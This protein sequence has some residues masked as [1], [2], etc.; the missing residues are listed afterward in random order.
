VVRDMLQLFK[1]GGLLTG[2]VTGSV[3]GCVIGSVTGSVTGC[4]IG[5]V[6]GSKRQ[7]DRQY[8]RQEPALQRAPVA[9]RTSV[10]FHLSVRAPTPLMLGLRFSPDHLTNEKYRQTG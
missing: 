9:H 1:G 3:T 7:Y 4:V 2:S 8:D 10:P 5:S 6:T